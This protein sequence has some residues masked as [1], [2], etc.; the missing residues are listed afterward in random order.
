MVNKRKEN[1]KRFFYPDEFMEVLE[2]LNDNQ[3]YTA[4]TM[5]NTGARINETRGIL[6]RNLSKKRETIVLEETKVRARLGET[7][8][9]P[10]TI[11]VS[12]EYFKYINKS[13][14]KRRILSTNAFNI[15]LRDA[16]VKAKVDKYEEF[17][18]HNLRKTFATW[19]LS[20]G[21]EP[22]KLSQ[23]LGHTLAELQKDYA[24][25]DV[26]TDEDKR[27]MLKILGN[28]PKK[29]IVRSVLPW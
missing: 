4:L 20:L 15:G 11:K 12:T 18:S 1:K 24:S 16:C 2:Y 8:P 7:S 21:V 13:I 17:S 10:R 28:L 3:K 6:S 22:F 26:F 27:L 14:S 29:M 19:M 5:I 9:D 23:H 25:N